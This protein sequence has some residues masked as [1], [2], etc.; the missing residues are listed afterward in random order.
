M[1]TKTKKGAQRLALACNL[2]VGEDRC[3][4]T[5]ADIQL[6]DRLIEI[7]SKY[8][9]F[10]AYFK[11]VEKCERCKRSNF[12]EEHTAEIDRLR[13]ENSSLRAWRSGDARKI[14]RLVDMLVRADDALATCGIS[15]KSPVRVN[16]HNALE[17]T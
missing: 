15:R 12:A 7:R 11:A 17:S 5:E 14:K 3:E 10:E 2:K 6:R 8:G 13:L 9:G 16:I 1:T 4:M